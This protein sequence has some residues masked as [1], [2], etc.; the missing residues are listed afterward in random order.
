MEKDKQ[1]GDEH[2]EEILIHHSSLMHRPQGSVFFDEVDLPFFGDDGQIEKYE[3]SGFLEII[4]LADSEINQKHQG[5]LRLFE[6]SR[7]FD[8]YMIQA[9]EPRSGE[10]NVNIMLKNK[11]KIG[12]LNNDT[13]ILTNNEFPLNDPNLEIFNRTRKTNEKGENLSRR[14]ALR[15]IGTFK[16]PGK[17]TR[18]FI[19]LRSDE[20]N[21]NTTEV[22][23]LDEGTLLITPPGKDPNI[24]LMEG[25]LMSL[26]HN[27]NKRPLYLFHE[28]NLYDKLTVE[29]IKVRYGERKF[30]V[31]IN[32]G[33]NQVAL[34]P[35][36]PSIAKD[37]LNL[38]S[39]NLS[40]YN[41]DWWQRVGLEIMGTLK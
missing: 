32:D 1:E 19:K 33:Q 10:K 11:D 25:M 31:L 26:E 28:T 38:Q 36:K 23:H 3:S 34:T 18:K 29:F 37:E 27:P 35:E 13:R 8:R 6:D 22:I 12:F 5:S 7:L 17:E 2:K 16:E 30:Q 14:V 24:G 15:V 4:L 40:L 39:W 9:I 20:E 21:T 41:T